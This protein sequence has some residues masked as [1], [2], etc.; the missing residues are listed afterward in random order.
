MDE[1]KKLAERLH[2]TGEA[3]LGQMEE[4]LGAM[5]EELRAANAAIAEKDEAIA[6]KNAA[7]ANAQDEKNQL[8][9]RLK[10]VRS[11]LL[12]WAGNIQEGV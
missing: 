11:G 9:E 4:E 6:A 3:L 8:A 7:L 10:N 12:Q 1:R 5:D 2:R